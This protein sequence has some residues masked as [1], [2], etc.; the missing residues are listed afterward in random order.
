MEIAAKKVK[1]NDLEEMNMIT[2]AQTRAI[3][4]APYA[5]FNICWF[6]SNHQNEMSLKMKEQKEKNKCKI[7]YGV[8]AV[9]VG[10]SPMIHFIHATGSYTPLFFEPSFI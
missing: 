2:A 6:V 7:R 9:S 10:F 5:V 8:R 3:P 4:A 1:T